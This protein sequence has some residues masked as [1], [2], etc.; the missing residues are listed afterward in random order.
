MRGEQQ[1]SAPREDRER[2]GAI[3]GPGALVPQ[4]DQLVGL[5][6]LADRDQRFEVVTELEVLR[7]LAHEDVAELV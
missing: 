3:D 5:V 4:G 6:E 2:P 7:W 1:P